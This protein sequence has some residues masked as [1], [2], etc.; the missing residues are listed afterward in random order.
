MSI[1]ANVQ[2]SYAEAYE[3][4]AECGGGFRGVAKNMLTGE[5]RRGDRRDTIEQARNDAKTFVFEFAAGR[6]MATG[7][8]RNP[9]GL[10]RCNYFI[11]SDEVDL[12][13]IA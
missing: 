8:F 1:L 11:R 7:T 4:K 6:N 3:I 9:K 10:W 5:V 2:L 12:A 13:P